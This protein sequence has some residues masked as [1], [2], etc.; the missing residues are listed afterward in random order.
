MVRRRPGGGELGGLESPM[1]PLGLRAPLTSSPFFF[2]FFF[3][4]FPFSSFHHADTP[5]E[6]MLVRATSAE[7]DLG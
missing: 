3:F 5:A 4:F 2:L 6:A 1:L 7:D